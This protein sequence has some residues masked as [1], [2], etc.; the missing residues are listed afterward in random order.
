MTGLLRHVALGKWAALLESYMDGDHRIHLLHVVAISVASYSPISAFAIGRPHGPIPASGTVGPVPAQAA[1]T[2][3]I[4][5]GVFL[6]FFLY[7]RV[8]RQITWKWWHGE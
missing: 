5:Q 2:P 8:S 1:L 4:R 6:L 7:Q 3:K